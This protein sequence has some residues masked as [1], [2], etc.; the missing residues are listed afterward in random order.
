MWKLLQ[1]KSKMEQKDIIFVTEDTTK[2]DWFLGKDPHPEYLQEFKR[3]TGQEILI[4]TLSDFWENCKEYL[5][6]SMDQF[7]EISSIKDQIEEKYNI[8][9]Q[10]EIC[11]KIEELLSESDEIKK[12]LEDAVDGCVDTPVLDELIETTIDSIDIE[13]YDDDYVYVTV[14]LRTEASFEAMNHTSGEDWSAGNGSVAL[15]IIALAEISV[16]W[17]SEDTERRV[18]KDEITVNEITDIEVLHNINN[19]N[20]HDTWDTKGAMQ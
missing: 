18:L 10:K 4:F 19:G 3:E 1:K 7:I 9:Y 12:L 5:D 2:G 14:Y 13:E 20:N 17:A 11:D 6:I 15:A 8:F 16:I